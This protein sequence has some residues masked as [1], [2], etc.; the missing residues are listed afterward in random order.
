MQIN[1]IVL[2]FRSDGTFNNT[3][4]KTDWK[5]KVSGTYSIINNTVQLSFK[6]GQESKKY[7]LAANSNLK[8][9]LV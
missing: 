5:T 7:K 1:N 4:N 3:L 2:Y 9:R 8:A 6:N